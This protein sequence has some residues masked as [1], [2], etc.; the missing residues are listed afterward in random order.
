MGNKLYVD[1]KVSEIEEILNFNKENDLKLE[2]TS[3][4][5]SQPL[6]L[7]VPNHQNLKV[8]RFYEGEDEVISSQAIML[9]N[10]REERFLLS[11]SEAYIILL[12]YRGKYDLS[13]ISAFPTS[14]WGIVESS[15]NMTPRGL[16]YAFS[17]S[18]EKSE[19][20]E[21]FLLSKRDFK[22]S[23]F[24][25]VLFIW[26]GKNCT[27]ILKSFALM[28]AFDMDK[29]L[30]NSTFLPYLYSG[31]WIENS[32]LQSGKQVK[33][34]EIISNT[35]ENLTDD[36]LLTPSSETVFNYQET[37]YLLQWLYPINKK[38]TK[39]STNKN[40][41]ATLFQKFNTNFLEN[42]QKSFY[43]LFVKLDK[44]KS[45]I[46]TN[47]NGNETEKKSQD[48]ESENEES[49]ENSLQS[50]ND[51]EEDLNL[52]DAYS[53]KKISTGGCIPKEKLKINLGEINNNFSLESSRNNIKK[54]K[55]YSSTE[56]N[57]TSNKIAHFSVPKLNMKFQHKVLNEE[58]ISQR[59]KQNS[60]DEEKL[61]SLSS[62]TIRR[63]SDL[64]IN[65]ENVLIKKLDLKNLKKTGDLLSNSE[66]SDYKINSINNLKIKTLNIPTSNIPTCK[67]LQLNTNINE[68][69]HELRNN[70][71]STGQ[72]HKED[73]EIFNEED[74]NLKDI[75]DDSQELDLRESERKKVL[76]DYFSKN[77]SVIIEDFLFLSSYNVAQNKEL[78]CQNKITHIINAAA[79]VCLNHFE[80]EEMPYIVNL[81]E[82]NNSSSS[83]RNS[84]K[85]SYL[86]FNLKDHSMENIECLFYEVINFIY[87]AKEKGGRVLVHCIQGIS[88]SVSLVLAYIIF[89]RKINYDEAFK[90]VQARRSISSPNLGFSIQ[91]QNFYQ[92]LFEP[93]SS[94]RLLPK[95]FA[96]GSFQ[97]E[98]PEKIVCRLVILFLFFKI[99]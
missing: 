9:P 88:R 11:S 63:A 31:Y 81:N 18:S 57:S 44:E 73:D 49:E 62:N 3:N 37:V 35:L 58:L 27:P 84:N 8:W 6:D 17:T 39:R 33:M 78:I 13:E 83:S 93:P 77:M 5:I 97:V 10:I 25:Y 76:M 45:E 75:L 46:N 72:E 92:R 64:I 95:I 99:F 85:I 80:E 20:L 43:D 70:S 7:N 16:K 23:D 21:S 98:Q 19:S 34:N 65:K 61:D 90:Y 69:S 71:D 15:S 67:P 50:L 82:K 29:K 47:R 28:K 26:N 36:N 1:T 48:E 89:I 52:E 94:F 4:N 60:K 32:K 38:S 24:K 66:T 55:T 2:S 87:N 12:V 30:S 14:L 68:V 86:S 40:N 56:T 59:T 22:D 79:D 91:L 74:N 54:E 51:V 96:V 53:P 42:S 41:P